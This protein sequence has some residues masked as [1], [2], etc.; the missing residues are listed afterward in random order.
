MTVTLFPS[1][2]PTGPETDE[3]LAALDRL[4]RLQETL[5][6]SLA[7]CQ[8]DDELCREIVWPVSIATLSG[9]AMV[10]RE[11]T[12]HRSPLAVERHSAGLR[13]PL[14]GSAAGRVYLAFCSAAQRETLEIAFFEGLS[15]PEIAA[16]EKVPLGTIKSRAARA[17][18]ALRALLDEIDTQDALREPK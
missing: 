9:Q 8:S 11:T 6:S 4:V 7:A 10:L 3:E 18:H 12:D 1:A 15:Y 13:V 14:L 17:L 5:E 16:R 2:P